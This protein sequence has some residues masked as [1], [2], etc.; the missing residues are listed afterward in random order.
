MEV[1]SQKP[2]KK[3]SQEGTKGR[4]LTKKWAKEF[5]RFGNTIKYLVSKSILT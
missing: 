3:V 1:S 2:R 5:I 4:K